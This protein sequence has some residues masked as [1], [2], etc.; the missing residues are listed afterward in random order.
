MINTNNKKIDLNIV[1]MLLILLLLLYERAA[2]PYNEI[3]LIVI[4][5]TLNAIECNRNFYF[6]AI[7]FI[8]FL[9]KFNRLNVFPT[10]TK[11]FFLSHF[12]FFCVFHNT[13]TYFQFENKWLNQKFMLT[14]KIDLFS[15]FFITVCTQFLINWISNEFMFNMDFQF[16]VR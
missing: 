11:L 4:W 5:L 2:E 15:P 10:K 6:Y 8:D 9:H 16:I 13:I 7:E 14:K 3:H 12:G 1:K